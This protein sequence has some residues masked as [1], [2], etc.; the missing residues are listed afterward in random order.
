MVP[1][2]PRCKTLLV[3]LCQF[4]PRPQYRTVFH[5]HEGDQTQRG[6][7]ERQD[8]TSILASIFRDQQGSFHNQWG[9]EGFQTYPT[10]WK[11]WVAKS[12]VTAPSVFL[13]R[14]WPAIALD[15]LSP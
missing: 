14:P 7:K 3:L 13:I 11:N 9:K 10:W 15:A 4:A 1:T 6:A 8:E 2:P 5:E 12:G